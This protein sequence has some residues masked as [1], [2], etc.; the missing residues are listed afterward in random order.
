[1]SGKPILHYFNGRGRME[2]VRW[3][4]AAAGVEFEEKL[5]KSAED[6]D[7]LIKSGNLMYQQV[8]MVEIDGLNLVQTRA[9]LKYIAAKYN[10]YGKDLKEKALIDMYVEG[11]RDLNEMIMYYP[12]C[13]P[14]EE[15]KNLNFILERATERFFPVYEKAL[16]SHGKNYLVGN[17][18]SWADIQLF[19]A[20]LMVEEL[21]SDILSAF[22]KLQEFKARMSKLPS[23]QKFL[24]PGSQRKEMDPMGLEEVKKI[25]KV[26]EDLFLKHMS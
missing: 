12:L 11:M 10:L 18:M 24:K 25:F 5:L 8:P 2:S 3:L 23:I 14:G 17:Q 19:E 26:D 1:M 15:E 7:N 6:F 9:I 21:K 13:Y 20:I 16:K 22:P 4:L